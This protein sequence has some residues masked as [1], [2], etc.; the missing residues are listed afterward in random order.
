MNKYVIFW[1]TRHHEPLNVDITV[2]DENDITTTVE[3]L[4]ANG[5]HVEYKLFDDVEGISKT[6]HTFTERK[7]ATSNL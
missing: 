5:V 7:R 4:R 6:L 2:T 3:K 1:R